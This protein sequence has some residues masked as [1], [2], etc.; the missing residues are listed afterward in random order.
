MAELTVSLRENLE[1]E[2]TQ[3]GSRRSYTVTGVTNA[4]K[5]VVRCTRNVDTTI[6]KFG[7][8]DNTS[9]AAINI[10]GTKYIR[11]TNLDRTSVVNLSF[12]IDTT[13]HAS[14][15]S[16]A[17][18]SATFALEPQQSFIMGTAHDSLCVDDSGATINTTL[19]DLESII[20]DTPAGAEV[21]IEV[22]IASTQ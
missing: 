1:L 19:H 12:Q 15:A 7:P 17:E 6:V 21:D 14:D 20:V 8:D 5:R 10:V 22:F 13:E 11:L 2:G 16:T 9:D 4:F 18:E 3:Y